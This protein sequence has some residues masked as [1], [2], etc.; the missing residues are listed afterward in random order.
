VIR[1][2]LY[3]GISPLSLLIRWQT[4]GPYSHAAFVLPSGSV[5]EAWPGGVQENPDLGKAHTA[6]TVVDLFDFPRSFSP[7]MAQKVLELARREVGSGY[8]YLGVLQFISRRRGA[9]NERWFCSELV[10]E[11]LQRVGISLLARVEPWQVSPSMLALSPLLT[12]V[13]TTFTKQFLEDE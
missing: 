11:M 2:A 5:I 7:E 6:G 12:H 4:R 1:L 8:D 9:H 10:F 3:R 13:G